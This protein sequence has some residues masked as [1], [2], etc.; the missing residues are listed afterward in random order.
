LEGGELD[1]DGRLAVNPSGGMKARGHPIGV[2]GLSSVVEMFTQLTGAAG[3]RQKPNARLG[4]I[5][6]AGGV[7]RHCY[8]FVMEAD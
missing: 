1:I 2:C 4:A 8:V 5:Q 7:S 6:S 3:E